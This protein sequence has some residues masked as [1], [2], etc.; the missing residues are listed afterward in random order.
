MVGRGVLMRFLLHSLGDGFGVARLRKFLSWI[1]DEMLSDESLEDD[2][3]IWIVLLKQHG[4][5][6]ILAV[7]LRGFCGDDALDLVIS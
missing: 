7:L 6:L 2:E 4:F 5:T 3:L 1:R